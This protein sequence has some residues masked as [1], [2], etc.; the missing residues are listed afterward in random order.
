MAKKPAYKVYSLDTLIKQVNE[1]APSRSRASDGWR[2]DKAHAARKSEHNP[3]EDGSVDAV[4]ITN[5]PAGGCDAQ[6]L[7]DAIVSSKDKRVKTLIHNGKI[8][9]PAKGWTWRKYSGKNPHK[10]HLHIDVLDSEQNSKVKWKIDA[11]FDK[12]A[13]PVATKPAPPKL[14]TRQVNSVLKRGSRGEFVVLLQKDLM[15]LG[16]DVGPDGADGVFELDTE[17]ALKAFQIDQKMDEVDGWAGPKTMAAIGKELSEMKSK[18]KIDKAE[19]AASEAEAK[20]DASRKVV[21]DAAAKNKVSITEWLAGITG[22]GG[23]ASVIK[24]TVDTATETSSSISNLFLTLGPWVLLG[25]VV[26]GGAGYIYYERRQKRL[27]AM[28]VK[29]VI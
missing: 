9:T 6:K 19:A 7:A 27:E 15:T 16:Y 10:T 24:Q 17:K 23:T 25:L 21:D 1:L 20:V 11:A 2:G 26:A 5:D 12:K 28:A 8:L 4:D 14:T 22:V 29:K 3:D 18:P 13:A